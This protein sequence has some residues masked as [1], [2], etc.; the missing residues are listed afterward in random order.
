MLVYPGKQTDGFSVGIDGVL[1]SIRLKNWRRG[2]EDA[3]Y[4]QMARKR[5]AAAADAVARWLVPSA[6]GEAKSGRPASWGTRGKRFFE[7]RRALLAIAMGTE[8]VTLDGT[9]TDASPVAASAPPRSTTTQTAGS[10]ALGLVGLV[11]VGRLRRR[12]G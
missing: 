9:T 4:L 3:G 2:I 7:A 12:R 5:D 8:R 6:F 1:P 11:G 10:L